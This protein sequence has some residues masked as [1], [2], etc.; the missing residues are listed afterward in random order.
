MADPP[1]EKHF[2]TG[3]STTVEIPPPRA[4]YVATPPAHLGPYLCPA[5]DGWGKRHEYRPASTAGELETVPCPA[6][7]GA[8]VLWRPEFVV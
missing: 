2:I 1:P 3:M 7:K 5:C 8:C 6:C 4:D